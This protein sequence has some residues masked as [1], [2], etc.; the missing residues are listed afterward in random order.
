MTVW[1]GNFIIADICGH[2]RTSGEG[3]GVGRDLDIPVGSELIVPGGLF[4]HQ[5]SCCRS[6]LIGFVHVQWDVEQDK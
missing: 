4:S 1:P 2:F 5:S 6:G 3:A